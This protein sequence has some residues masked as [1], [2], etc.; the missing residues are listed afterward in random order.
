MIPRRNDQ[1]KSF[2]QRQDWALLTIHLIS[3]NPP[4]KLVCWRGL[5][6]DAA[7]WS[8]DQHRSGTYVGI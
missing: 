1:K 6:D 4:V 7:E 2:M 5:P 3:E 8:K